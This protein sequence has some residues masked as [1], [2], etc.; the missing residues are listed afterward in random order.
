MQKNHIIGADISKKRIDLVHHQTTTHLVIENNTVGF[1]RLFKWLKELGIS[2]NDLVVVME[3]TGY[4]S[5]KLEQCLHQKSVRFAKIAALEIK[6]SMGLTRGKSDKIDAK[7]IARYGMEKL[8]VLRFTQPTSLVIQELKHL[9]TTRDMLTRHNRAYQCYFSELADAVGVSKTNTSLKLINLCYKETEQKLKSIDRKI[10]ELIE[11]DEALHTNFCLL[12]SLK[13]VGLV[14]ATA[15]LIAT[16]NFTRFTDARKF[17]C[18]CGTAPFEHSSGTSIKG[19]T[20]VSHLANKGIK[21]LLEM[22]A[23]SAIQHDKELKA[24]YKRRVD[25]GKNKTSTLNIVRNKLITRMFAVI[26]RQ[27]P[28]VEDYLATAA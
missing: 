26:K 3:H 21:S 20:R 17:A 2:I 25:E 16:D 5:Y 22:A 14:L 15:V 1:R 9:F 10:M 8:D 24:Y 27:T 23:R 12:T 11:S 7:R 4:Y 19:K 28:Y 6:R 18:Y 13:G